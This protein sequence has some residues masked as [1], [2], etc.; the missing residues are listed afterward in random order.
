MFSTLTT[1]NR[2]KAQL[3]LQK[4]SYFRASTTVNEKLV[5]LRTTTN[6]DNG[7]EGNK[8]IIPTFNETK[9]E[10]YV[11]KLAKANFNEVR[12]T[13]FLLACLRTIKGAE[14][15]LK[16]SFLDDNMSDERFQSKYKNFLTHMTRLERCLIDLQLFCHNKLK[17]YLYIYQEYGQINHFIQNVLRE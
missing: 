10:E 6:E 11:F 5:W 8:Q 4:D 7:Q 9:K 12:M 1:Y 13:N 15:Y 17:A 2:E 3:F 16:A 14:Q